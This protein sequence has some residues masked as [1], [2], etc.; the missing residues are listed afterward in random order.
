MIEM[1][2]L[3]ES[4][5]REWKPLRSGGNSPQG[6]LEVRIDVGDV[7]SRK[8][9]LLVDHAAEETAAEAAL[10]AEPPPDAAVI[11]PHESRRP[12]IMV[13]RRAELSLEAVWHS[14]SPVALD[15]AAGRPTR[16]P[17]LAVHEPVLPLAFVFDATL[18]GQLPLAVQNA[19][20]ET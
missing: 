17:H 6:H 15:P 14:E 19:A 18:E 16:H 4:S 3:I 9:P 10:P 5:E 7:L 8:L 20:V 1:N 12:L 11:S 13:I 2:E